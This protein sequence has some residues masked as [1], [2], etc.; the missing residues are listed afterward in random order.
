M[1]G[2]RVDGVVAPDL[3]VFISSRSA[4]ICDA[5]HD[6]AGVAASGK[7]LRLESEIAV[8]R[9]E[10]AQNKTSETSSLTSP[11]S[12]QE[13]TGS[14]TPGG[15]SEEPGTSSAATHL[16]GAQPVRQL[17]DYSVTAEQVAAAVRNGDDTDNARKA[18]EP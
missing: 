8:L 3:S 18:G 11:T 4:P 5:C 13:R 2:Q 6:A 10:G 14:S 1:D 16:E 17:R 12:R 7:I 9:L 15:G